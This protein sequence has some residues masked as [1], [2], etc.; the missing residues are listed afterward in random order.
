MNF[1]NYFKILSDETRIRILLLLLKKTLCVCQMQ[2]IMKIPQSKVSKH[3]SRL[4]DQ[5][6]VTSYQDGKFVKYKLENDLFLTYIL[7]EIV[8]NIDKDS[9]FF[10]D[11]ERV[12]DFD[13]LLEGQK[14]VANS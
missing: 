6:I 8:D 1:V 13:Y 10:K 12:N 14:N 7:R 11:A 9:I 5:K 3:L 2:A 4:R